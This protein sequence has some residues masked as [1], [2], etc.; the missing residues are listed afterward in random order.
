[1]SGAYDYRLEPAL[2]AK[3][4]DF[5]V[6][7]LGVNEYVGVV[8]GEASGE[9]A[10]SRLKLVAERLDCP[11]LP[12]ELRRFV[13]WVAAYTLSPPGA[14]LR[15]CMSVSAALDPPAGRIAYALSG[16]K[17]TRMT[18]ARQRVL[19]VL[20]DGPPRS[21]ADIAEAAAA[22]PGVV[23]GLLEAGALKAVE[24]PADMAYPAPQHGRPGP[25]LSPDQS[26]AAARLREAVRSG[27]FSVTLLEG[28]TG[29]GKTEVYFEAVAAALAQGRQV[30]VLLPEIA[31]SA[32]WL[33]RFEQRFGVRPVEWHSELRSTE[34]RRAWRAVAEGG[35]HVVVGARSALFL[36]FPALGLIVVDEEHDASFKQED[37]VIYNARDMAV[38]RASLAKIPA[39]LVSATPSLETIAN[40][41]QGRYAR[42]HLPERHAR[43]AMPEIAAI[44][45]RASPPPRG[46]WLSAPLHDALAETLTAGEQ[47]LLFLNRRGYAPLTL[48]GACGHRLE[49]PNC[50]AWLVEHRLARR[51]QCHHCGHA[52][53]LPKTCPSCG[54]EDRLR[55]CGPGVERLAEEI[56]AS[57]PD[58]RTA[59]MASDT[60]AGPRAA[61]D[62]VAQVANHEIDLL[63]GTQIVAKGHHFP[64]L[65]LVGVVD[66]DLGLSGGDLRAAE[67]TYQL[68]TQV[69]GRAGRAERPGRVLLQ[70]FSPEHPVMHA[71]VSGDRDGFIAAEMQARRDTAM[72]PFGRLAALI[73][74]G[75]NLGSVQRVARDLGQHSPRGEGITVLGPAPAPLSLL[76]GRHRMRLLLK[77]Q[78]GANIQQVLREWLAPIKVPNDVRLA[79]DVDPYS[80][81]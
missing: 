24:L 18:A 32:Q 52:M 13:D 39:L 28:V 27:A 21:I 2:D 78:R 54:A 81:L 50:S 75:A 72:P 47:A 43:A 19:N 61:A 65:T 14:V 4:G 20:A 63:I 36:P 34:R 38:V 42:L 41:E 17:P 53:A 10:E 55:A 31:L 68:L 49:C 12:E 1:L 79:V 6:A 74:S 11:P 80:F 44:D 62:L 25:E 33:D 23:R 58:A 59:V 60:L 22:G 45:M 64:M 40:V 15:M 37:G 35:A 9:V 3:P 69:S 51:L 77:M 67:R 66:A 48:C 71:L 16:D 29:A 73:V 46:H 70:T 26:A 76:R 30:L 7:P 57:F 56:A 5:V 8:W